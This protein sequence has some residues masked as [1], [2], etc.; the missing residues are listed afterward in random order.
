MKGD[1]G[2]FMQI[3]S[4]G[5]DFIYLFIYFLAELSLP[6]RVAFHWFQQVGLLSSCGVR[7]SSHCGG[8][9]HCRTRALGTQA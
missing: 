1:Y 5:M 6:P 4:G 3:I 8:F 9:S 7:A 2:D